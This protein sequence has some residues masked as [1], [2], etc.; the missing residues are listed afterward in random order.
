MVQ[1]KEWVVA[2]HLFLSKQGWWRNPVNN[3]GV[4]FGAKLGL[5]FHF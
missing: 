5:L 1:Y 3:E 4:G 2:A